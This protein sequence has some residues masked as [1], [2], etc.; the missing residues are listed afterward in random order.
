MAVVGNRMQLTSLL[1]LCILTF[2][3]IPAW[4]EAQVSCDGIR[5]QLS[6]CANYVKVGGDVPAECC[7]GLKTVANNLKTK[8]D[9]Q[10]ACQCIKDGV[11]K[12]SPEQLKRAQ[13]LPSYCKVPLPF[14]I[15][16]DVDCSA[17]PKKM[18]KVTGVTFFLEEES[19]LFLEVEATFGRL[20]LQGEG[21]QRRLLP[22]RGGDAWS[23]LPQL[24]KPHCLPTEEDGD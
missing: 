5:T 22:G 10:R 7:L 14:K 2:A 23:L 3:V 1:L 9:R 13:G 17:V 20:L 6:P 19:T 18:K 15:G 8:L 11:V 12:A 24:K 4:V 21:D 16:V